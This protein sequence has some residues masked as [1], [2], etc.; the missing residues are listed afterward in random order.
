MDKDGAD[1]KA[2]IADVQQQLAQIALQSK[3]SVKAPELIKL[4]TIR[5]LLLEAL[6][7]AQDT[8][9]KALNGCLS[10]R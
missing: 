1:K 8:V 3:K 7:P 5:K 9:E 2:Q 4:L 6:G 10:D